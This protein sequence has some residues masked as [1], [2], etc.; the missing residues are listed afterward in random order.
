MLFLL[1]M[2]IGSSFVLD[3][4]TDIANKYL[5]Y[6]SKIPARFHRSGFSVLLEEKGWVL[7]H[8]S[9]FLGWWNLIL[10]Q[11]SLARIKFTLFAFSFL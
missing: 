3:V 2:V 8:P 9:L 10:A 6:R 1:L 7:E 11:G 5:A 4:L